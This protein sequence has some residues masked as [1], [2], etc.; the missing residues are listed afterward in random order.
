LTILIAATGSLD[1]Q[2]NGS[3]LGSAAD[4]TK[5]AVPGV[6]VRVT[7]VDTNQTEQT[8]TDPLGQYRFLVLPVGRYRLEAA[9]QGFQKF[10]AAD[11]VLTVNEQH[12]VDIPM[13]V[14]SLEQLVEVT[15]NP[16]QVETTVTQ[17]GQVIDEKKM[18]NLPLNGR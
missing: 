5:A 8:V 6:A 12:R 3:I 4:S 14:G 2:V 16:V 10:V 13:N 7:N 9:L 11:I 15:A 1:A 18:I 17:L